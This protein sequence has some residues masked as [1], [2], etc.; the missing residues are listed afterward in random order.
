[1]DKDLLLERLKGFCAYRERCT[2]EVVDKARRLG[3]G[4]DDLAKLLKGLRNEGFLDDARYAGLFARSKFE[5]NGWGRLKIRAALTERDL[6]AGLI[7][8]ALDQIDP[9]QYGEKLQML[10]KRK[11]E[12]LTN[13]GKT[14][15]R[16]KAASYLMQ[17][18]YEAPLVWQALDHCRNKDSST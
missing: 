12:E 7:H 17:K 11:V 18:G 4:P 2:R 3:A 10:C 13:Q 8:L 1:M 14:K 16:E 9:D 5:H 6:A 15:T